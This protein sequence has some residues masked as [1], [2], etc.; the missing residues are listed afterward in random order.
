MARQARDEEYWC[1]P[2]CDVFQM[3]RLLP[4]QSRFARLMCHPEFFRHVAPISISV[5]CLDIVDPISFAF[6]I[7]VAPMLVALT[8]FFYLQRCFHFP[9][10]NHWHSL[11]CCTDDQHQVSVA[12]PGVEL[13]YSSDDDSLVLYLFTLFEW[14]CSHY[15]VIHSQ[16]SP[17]SMY[18]HIC[19]Y[20]SLLSFFVRARVGDDIIDLSVVHVALSGIIFV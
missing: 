5:F 9:R 16:S 13:F 12:F 15:T 18:G 11:A 2:T 8:F 10:W 6:V 1:G 4:S 20:S 14:H 3:R 19:I 17:D 7:S